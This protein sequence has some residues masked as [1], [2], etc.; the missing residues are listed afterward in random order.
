MSPGH[1][2][3]PS[4][5]ELREALSRLS[6]IVQSL[7]LV[8][9][10]ASANVAAS[11]DASQFPLPGDVDGG[12]TIQEP[13]GS[14]ANSPRVPLG[15]PVVF[16]DDAQQSGLRF[17][18]FNGA[19]RTPTRKIFELTGGGVGVLDFDGDW[20]PDVFLTQGVEWPF[21]LSDVDEF[22]DLSTRPRQ[23]PGD[24][25][26]RNQ[27]GAAFDDVSALAG[28][29]EHR[30]GQGVAAG[31]VNGDGFADLY[32][33]NIGQNRLWLNNG[34]GSFSAREATHQ[35][36]RA[37]GRQAARL[38]I[39]TATCIRTCLTSIILRATKCSA[40][41]APSGQGAPIRACQRILMPLRIASCG[42]TLMAT[43]AQMVSQRWQLLRRERGW[44]SRSGLWKALPNLAC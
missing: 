4:S 11:V 14:L 12:R 32:V 25:L 9:T 42:M 10:I 26:Y 34:D 8:Q 24:R 35:S 3:F 22:A 30:F 29:S 21:Q 2:T 36:K 38:S 44:E 17:C 33:A 28:I 18:F 7:P 43:S 6:D 40:A 23:S 13:S 37:S 31:D 15:S 20:W 41:S 39:W 27:A 19:D 1:G 16:R 5:A